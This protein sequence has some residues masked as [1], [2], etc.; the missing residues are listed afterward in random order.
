MEGGERLTQE[1][2]VLL[3]RLRGG[4]HIMNL[5]H[6]VMQGTPPEHVAA[7]VKQVRRFT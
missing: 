2:D 1:A 7:L 5:G 3:N 6:G 4:P